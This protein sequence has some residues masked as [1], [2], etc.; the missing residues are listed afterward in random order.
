MSNYNRYLKQEVANLKEENRELREEVMTLRQYVESLKSIVEAVD[1]LAPD[2][3]IMGLLDRILY[4][5]M[6][7][8]NSEDGSLLVQDE[9]TEE[10]VFVLSR[11]TIAEEELIGRRIPSGRGIGGWVAKNVRPAIVNNVRA[12]PRFYGR[13]DEV[14]GFET[15]SIM[16]TPI[17]GGGR[18]LGV[19]EVLNKREGAPYLEK[20]QTLLV[21]LCRFAG[22]VVS[23]L[24]R[25]EVQETDTTTETAAPSV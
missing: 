3:D 10:L 25:R 7:V 1:R 23:A 2:G 19:I 16:A 12:D 22:E 9:E 21:L 11:G 5:A 20:D 14:L 15:N 4:S 13:L 8:T 18:V 17:V 24:V 6:L